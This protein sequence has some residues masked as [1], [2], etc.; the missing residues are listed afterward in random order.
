M[1]QP[2]L[3]GAGALQ[4]PLRILFMVGGV[5]FATPGGGIMPL[6]NAQMELLGAAFLLPAVALALWAMRRSRR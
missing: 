4:W 1:V 3:R 5:V 6:S 2:D